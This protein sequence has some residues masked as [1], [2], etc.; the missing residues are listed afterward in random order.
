MPLILKDSK[1]F[2]PKDDTIYNIVLEM[3]EYEQIKKDTEK[4]RV[5]LLKIW[6]ENKKKANKELKEILKFEIKPYDILVVSKKLNTID[7]TDVGEKKV[8][9]IVWG[10]AINTSNSFVTIIQLIFEIIKKEF[11]GYEE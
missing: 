7:T 9:S 4:F 2:I 10:R 6:D 5:A 3:K 11:R 8:N 1:N